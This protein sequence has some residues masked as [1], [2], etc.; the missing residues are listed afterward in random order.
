MKKERIGFLSTYPPRE[1]GIATFTQDLIRGL[2]QNNQLQ[3]QV[4]AISDHTYS[5]DNDVLFELAQHNA[6]DYA[7]TAEYINDSSMKAIVIEHEYGIF[8]GDDGEYVL[9]L[10]DAVYKPVITTLHT[11][12]PNPSP[13]QFHVLQQ[14]CKRSDKVIAMSQNSKQIL[15]EVYQIDPD[16]VAVLHHGVPSISLPSREALK[17]KMNLQNKTIISTF[18]L[19]APGKGLE[20]GIEAAGIAAQKHPELVYYIIGKTHP[21][22]QKQHGEAYR[23]KLQQL[24]RARG[25]D[26]N[27]R[28]I[29]KYLSKQEIMQWL[30]M[31]DLY[32]TPYLGK[33]QAVSGTLAYAVGSGRVIISTPYSYATEMLAS[34]RGMLAEFEDA[35]S[36]AQC[37]T[38]LLDNPD[39]RKTMEENTLT[40]GKTMSWQNVASDFYNE[41]STLFS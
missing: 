36:L 26:H 39:L 4:F 17:K 25:L 1:C 28:F 22:I 15:Q 8:G 11:V 2:K 16:K 23:E 6:K 14:L 9:Y 40:L 32:M 41:V 20:Y 13:S 21:V 33:D 24:V 27:V 18:G 38:H 34:N 7:A 31:S 10:T 29:N 35:I 30:K 19:L 12:L 3:P 37:I 5:Y